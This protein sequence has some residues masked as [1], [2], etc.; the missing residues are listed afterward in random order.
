MR[1]YKTHR[2]VFAGNMV[3][4]AT[5][6]SNLTQVQNTPGLETVLVQEML[7]SKHHQ[8]L[9][10][11]VKP[12][13]AGCVI[14]S[15][16]DRL[17]EWKFADS[18]HFDQLS[19]WQRLRDR[20]MWKGVTL[21][22]NIAIPDGT[23]LQDLSDFLYELRGDNA[24]VSV[25]FAGAL[26]GY[27]P[28]EIPRNMCDLF[29]AKTGLLEEEVIVQV[30]CEMDEDEHDWKTILG[31]CFRALDVMHMPQALVLNTI[32]EDLLEDNGGRAPMP[33]AA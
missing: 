27:L 5:V 11:L 10:P 33:M 21:Q 30:N 13:V 29:N 22:A 18:F 12:I 32:K 17:R 4:T 24:I 31:R 8:T 3:N 1:N 20:M 28:A 9:F 6:L 26:C 2:T 15:G 7:M 25:S 14:A 19:K 16:R 23:S